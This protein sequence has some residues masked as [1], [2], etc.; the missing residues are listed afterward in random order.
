MTKLR[1][2][3][4]LRKS[5]EAKEKQALSIKSQKDELQQKFPDINIVEWIV[6][7]KS[8]FKPYN[9]PEFQKMMENLESGKFDGIVAWHPDRLSR[10]EID[11]ATLTYSVRIG[12]VKDLKFGSYTF[13]NTPDGIKHLQNSLSDSQYYSSKLG[14]DVKRGLTTKL[15]MGRRPCQAPIGYLNT[16]WSTRGENKIII[17]PE[18]FD[19][20]R[21]M[22]DMMLTGNY[23]TSHV[24]DIA[25]Q[26]WNLLTLKKKKIGGGAIGYSTIYKM[27][28][29]IFY[30]GSFYYRG[31]LYKGDHAPMITMSEFDRVQTLLKEKGKPRAKTYT[32]AYGSG[33]LKCGECHYSFVGIEK[34]KFIKTAGQMKQYILYLCGSKKEKVA[35]GQKAN[36]NEIKLE[37]QIIREISR[38]AIDED[39][40]RWALEVIQ[41]NGFADNQT[42]TKIEEA[43]LTNLDAKQKELKRLIEMTTRGLISDEE[44]KGN[45]SHP[46]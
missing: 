9:R 19:T 27:F 36:I 45:P 6:E 23:T 17:D 8:A 13:E 2:L 24:R 41:E 18:R 31:Q 39:F 4:Y 35:C 40:L 21:S 15:K 28:T 14:V 42:D 7:E 44:F 32:F 29:N 1:Y 25:T 11:A 5:S 10:N 43:R 16:K 22:W 12:T 34:N 38:Y 46:N 3:A 37:E 30:T 33:C 20:V 26:E